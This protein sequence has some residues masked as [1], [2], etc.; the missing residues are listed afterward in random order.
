MN[1]LMS[2]RAIMTSGTNNHHKTF[3]SFVYEGDF[4]MVYKIKN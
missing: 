4:K 3:S 1:I 2:V